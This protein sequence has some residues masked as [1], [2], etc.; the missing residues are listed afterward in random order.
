MIDPF[1]LKECKKNTEVL[2]LKIKNLEFA[3]SQ[4]EKM[5]SDSQINQDA[6]IFLRRKIAQSKQDLE[7]LY[8]IKNKS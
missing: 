6:L 8:L 5:I 4:S 1:T 3:I 7:I 2:E